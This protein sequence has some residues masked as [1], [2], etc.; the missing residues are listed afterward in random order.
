MKND[1]CLHNPFYYYYS[2]RLQ[3]DNNLDDLDKHFLGEKGRNCSLREHLR[4]SALPENQG[5]KT[6]VFPSLCKSFKFTLEMEIACRSVH[7]S[8]LAR[9]PKWRWTWLDV[10]QLQNL[11]RKLSKAGL[12]H[13]RH[14]HQPSSPCQ[15]SPFFLYQQLL[16]ALRVLCPLHSHRRG[17]GENIPTSLCLPACTGNLS[18][19]WLFTVRN[20]IWPSDI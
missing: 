10:T 20:L 6:I 1:Y 18:P 13:H 19:A 8:L 3:S 4:E 5:N 16:R 11:C 14:L 17:A 9:N 2:F 15:N 12:Q 7:S